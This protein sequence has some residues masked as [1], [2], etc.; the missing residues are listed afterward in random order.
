MSMTSAHTKNVTSKLGRKGDAR[1]HRAVTAR[2]QNPELSLFEALC[3]G[4]FD[5]PLNEDASALDSEKV[6]L[7]QRKN[8]LSRRL[9]LA[10]KHNM[11][12][13][14]SPDHNTEHSSIDSKGHINRLIQ[15]QTQS[16]APSAIGA[17]ALQMKR[18]HSELG[19]LSDA[20]DNVGG[21]YQAEEPAK[22]PRIAK[23]HPQ[24]APLFVPPAGSRNASLSTGKGMDPSSPSPSS[25]A[26]TV[27]LPPLNMGLS[28]ATNNIPPPAPMFPSQSTPRASSVAISSLAHSAQSVGLTLEQLAMT[29]SSNP[30]GLVKVLADASSAEAQARKN[31]LAE[32]LYETDCKG[33][34]SKSMLMAGFDPRDCQPSSEVYREFAIKAWQKEG[35]RLQDQFA[36][37]IDVSDSILD[38]KTTNQTNVVPA[39]KCTGGDGHTHDGS[40]KGAHSHN[41]CE[42][43]HIHRIDGQCGHKAIIHKPKNGNAHIDFVVGNKVECYH[44]IEPIGANMDA[45]WPS[46]YKCKEAGD[47]GGCGDD[48]CR[49]DLP[50]VNIPK[51]IE[52]SEINLQD[53]EWNYDVNGSID[54]GVAG[55]FR[56]GGRAD[57]LTTV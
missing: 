46:R 19:D 27:T 4:G 34:Y 32:R 23:F 9:R 43:R 45:A 7:G 53:P 52:L 5:Y 11:D 54:G 31:E 2:L 57:E 35:K 17:R 1:M 24:F 47:H 16:R 3:I 37:L 10:K 28:V 36:G 18:D 6:S 15:Q 38:V 12:G 49:G 26:G 56:L 20:E 48:N 14:E 51:V 44:G 30:M 22:Q 21:E 50:D 29:L 40:A 39:S 33:L 8:Q 25:V 41:A 13:S 42:A 55:L